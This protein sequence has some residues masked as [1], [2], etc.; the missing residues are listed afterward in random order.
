[1]PGPKLA[2][3]NSTNAPPSDV[4][5]ASHVGDD[6]RTVSSYTASSKLAYSGMP[7]AFLDLDLVIQK[8]NHAF[9]N[10][11]AFLGDARGK[12]LGDLLEARQSN[13]LQ[14][15]RS[16]L[17]EERD[18]REPAYMAPITPVGKDPMHAVMDLVTDQDIDHVSHGFTARP[19]F[20]NFRLPIEGQYQPLQVQIRLAKTSL[21]F[22]TL[23]VHPLPRPAASPL[24]PQPLASPTPMH[25]LQPMSMPSNAPGTH[26]TPQPA[27]PASSTSSAPGSPYFNFSTIRTSLPSFSPSSY[28]G[29]PLYG[30]SPTTGPETGYFP[31]RQP[32]LQLPAAT[33]PSPYAPELRN[34]S[35]TSEPLRELNRPARFEG[36]HL[37]PIRTGPPSLG[38]PLPM[39]P[40]E[41][42]LRRESDLVRQREAPL[43][44]AQPRPHSP[45]Q[46]KR[47][48]LNIH[49]VLG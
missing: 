23:V 5:H 29:S 15:L 34:L 11:V 36:L 24:H 42:M 47:R 20:L 26:F 49:A 14:R 25:A 4:G 8:S 6:G 28:G 7:V 16:L 3:L 43:S 45:E 44:A 41:S 10:L 32:P 30:Y 17:R 40:R 33:N 21:Y 9:A 27:R 38:S 39:D 18:E 12:Q 46:D 13:S 1:M 37:P 31:T 22:V 35:V 19:M 2:H 48:R